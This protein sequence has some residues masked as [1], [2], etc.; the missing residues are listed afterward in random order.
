MIH[1]SDSFM[2][3][4]RADFGT[5]VISLFVITVGI[6]ALSASVFKLTKKDY[7]LLNF[8]LFST[9]FGLRWLA[10]IPTIITILGF[11]FSDPYFHGVLTYL[12]VIPFCALLIN[13]FGPGVYNT[14]LLVFYSSIT[15][16]IIAISLD[17]LQP[18]RQSDVSINRILV[19]AWGIIG[20][21]NIILVRRKRDIELI[22]FKLVFF[23]IILSFTIDNIAAGLNL[24]IPNNLERPSFLLLM[25]GL[26]FVAI[27]HTLA[28]DRKLLS[29]EQ[30]IGIARKIQLSNLPAHVNVLNNLS[31]AARYVPMTTIAGD[32]YDI[33]KVDESRIGVFIAD[34][35]GHGVGAALIGSMLKVC[36]ASQAQNVSDP[37]RVLAEINRILHGKLKSSFVTA[38]SVFI[39]LE[40]NK[41]RYAAAGHPPPILWKNTSNETIRLA[42]GGLLLGPFAD[43]QYTNAEYEFR[44]HDRLVLYTD[45]ITE[46]RTKSGDLFSMQRL[47][48]L[49][50]ENVNHTAEKCADFLIARL[51]QWSGKD[52]NTSLDDDLTLLIIDLLPQDQSFSDK[53]L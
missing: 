19:I 42:K 43:A 20:I 30:E 10:E 51:M 34:V 24:K 48:D 13:I 35:S 32:F 37:A 46:T 47:E 15:N 41:L 38:C 18:E 1:I 50:R 6:I 45:G 9:L 33:Y 39:D 14:F 5:I 8:G 27:H 12:F 49:I 26:G 2:A 23:I 21:V 11:P 3:A 44:Q 36:F 22:V 7:T 28:N 31:M 29:I 53:T 40:E 52:P 25:L 17:L 16:A 4:I